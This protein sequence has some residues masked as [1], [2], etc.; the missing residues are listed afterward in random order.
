MKAP[1]FITANNDGINDKFFVMHYEPLASFS[2]SI[3]NP[4]GTV[5]HSVADPGSQWA[6]YDTEFMNAPG[7]IPYLY[8]V[9]VTTMSGASHS[10]SKVV[11]VIRDI[12][13]ECIS[14]DIQPIAG[15]QFDPRRVCEFLYPSNDL[16]CVQ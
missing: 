6:G 14:A 16:V 12:Y 8:T 7:P 9:Q 15:D 3:M 5:V 2:L 4:N 1:N 10:S 11:H 13:N